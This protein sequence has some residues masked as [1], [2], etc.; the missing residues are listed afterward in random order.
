MM[1]QV[2]VLEER[3]YHGP[4]IASVIPCVFGVF[5]SFLNAFASAKRYMATSPLPVQTTW[6]RDADD[7]NPEHGRWWLTIASEILDNENFA[8]TPGMPK[9]VLVHIDWDGYVSKRHQPVNRVFKPEERDFHIKDEI[10]TEWLKEL[11]L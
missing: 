5:S 2:W 6:V 1:P 10:P 11:L 7:R 4:G 8:Y 3:S 9:N